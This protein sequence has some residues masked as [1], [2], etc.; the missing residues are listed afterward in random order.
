M[1]TF[2]VNGDISTNG[3]IK[4]NELSKVVT[5]S[6]LA[7][8]IENDSQ[9]G[10]GYVNLSELTVGAASK[11]ATARTI[12]INLASTSAAS[13]DGSANITPGVTGTL[14][15]SNGGTGRGSFSA[16]HL[17]LG[18]GS[19]GLKITDAHINYSAGTTSAAGYEELVIGNSKNATTSGNTFGRLTIYSTSS[20]GGRLLAHE[21]TNWYDHY[22]PANG[23]TLLNTNGGEVSG[24]I[25][26]TSTGT[27]SNNSGN[28]LL[29]YNNSNAKGATTGTALGYQ[30][31]TT[32]LRGTSL[33]YYDSSN[34]YNILT[35]KSTI[36]VA[37]GGTGCTTAEDAGIAFMNALPLGSTAPIDNTEIIMQGVGSYTGKFYRKPISLVWDY[38]KTKSDAAYDAKGAATAAA[39]AV[40]NE[41]LNGAGAAYDTLKELGDLID[42]NQDAIEILE[43]VAASKLS[44]SG[45]T[46]TGALMLTSG[47]HYGS[48]FPSGATTGQ[49]FFKKV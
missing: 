19:N 30:G 1:G 25:C 47:V 35:T 44:L 18:N 29:C 10:F 45:G 14:P 36:T 17:V 3:N 23:G 42:N 24:H 16:G 7:A 2:H 37:Q 38:I 46:L 28:Y 40:K 21:S 5:A 26:L 6:K 15:V 32:T 4:I 33:K 12:T 41:L 20:A 8:F 43:T 11:L 48:T 49:I 22:L 9:K 27:I 39:A 31:N 34:T 13:F